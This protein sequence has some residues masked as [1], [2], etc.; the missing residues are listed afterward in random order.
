MVQTFDVGDGL[1]LPMLKKERNTEALE[2]QGGGR[3]VEDDASKQQANK[4]KEML[5][6]RGQAMF[7][8]LPRGKVMELRWR[9][10]CTTFVLVPTLLLHGD[11]GW[12]EAC[13]IHTRA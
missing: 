5:R 2:G 11:A 9:K 12:H 13:K 8:V 6:V 1:A 10:F 3:V 4:K 7:Y